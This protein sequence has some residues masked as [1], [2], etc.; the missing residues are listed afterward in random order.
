M[1]L[2]VQI[3]GE[4]TMVLKVQIEGELTGYDRY[5]AAIKLFELTFNILINSVLN[6]S[7]FADIWNHC[8]SGCHFILN[9]RLKNLDL[10]LD[11]IWSLLL[12]HLP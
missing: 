4:L 9:A 5:K 2:K 7:N 1:V 3:E 11:F 12:S 6:K 8:M 10:S